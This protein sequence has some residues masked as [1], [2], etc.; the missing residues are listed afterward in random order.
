MSF[1]LF[2]FDIKP[3]VTTF[4]ASCF[5]SSDIMGRDPQNHSWRS[6]ILFRS[7]RICNCLIVISTF[8]SHPVTSLYKIACKQKINRREWNWGINRMLTNL[9]SVHIWPKRSI[10]KTLPKAQRTRGLSSFFQSNLLGYSQ[11]QTQ[12]LIELHLQNLDP[13]FTSKSQLNITS[14]TKLRIQNTKPSFSIS[15]KI[16]LHN[17]CK[18]SAAKYWPNAS[19][20][21]LPELQHQNLDQTLC[22]K[23]EQKFGFI[24]KP[25]LPSMQQTVANTIFIINISKSANLN[26]FWVGTSI[27]S[28]SKLQQVLSCHLHMPGSH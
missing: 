18:T 27:K 22:S 5:K 7:T 20:K 8:E 17:L 2:Q 23:S 24:T 14:S 26:K 4:S 1:L 15:T 12:I 28:V 21:I 25:Q 11:V 3:S 6:W 10:T 9:H 16:Q 13:A 19:L